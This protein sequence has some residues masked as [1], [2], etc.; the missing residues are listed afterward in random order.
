MPF[1]RSVESLPASVETIAELMRNHATCVLT[2]AGISTD[3]GIPDYRGGGKI[4]TN[5]IDFATFISSETARKKYWLRGFLGFTRFTEAL[6][7]RG[8]R[9]VAA[10]EQN[11]LVNGVVTQNVD[12]LHRKAGSS[13]V[14]E[15]HGNVFRLVCLNCGQ[16]FA[17]AKFNA[18]FAQ[19]NPWVESHPDLQH[20]DLESDDFAA[21]TL[22][23]AVLIP[24]CTVCAGTLKPDVVFFGEYMNLQTYR[25]A[26]DIVKQ[27]ELLMVVGSSL[28][29]NSAVRLVEVARKRKLPLVIVN[30]GATKVDK[31]AAVRLDAGATEVLNDVAERLGISDVFEDIE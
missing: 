8:H 3:S 10:L 22:I 2:G 1:I 29:V 5:R 12:G 26:E 16:R 28:V 13:R 23:D 21:P 18:L 20:V 6:P 27:A 14:A 25:S 19:L 7:N 31:L 15:L 9:L 17:R 11:G 4:P 24:P 30:R